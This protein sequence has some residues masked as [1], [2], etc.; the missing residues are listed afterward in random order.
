[1]DT[2]SESTQDGLE[3]EL[4]CDYERQRADRIARNKQIL[5]EMGIISSLEA[6]A[7][8]GRYVKT[9]SRKRQ[10]EN[11]NPQNPSRRSERLHVPTRASLRIKGEAPELR[12]ALVPEPRYPFASSML[13]GWNLVQASRD[14][15]SLSDSYHIFKAST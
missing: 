8:S 12:A 14:E 13:I 2:A 10:I 3:V 4:M 7:A 11:N 9:K 1:M 5:V 15:E 6:F